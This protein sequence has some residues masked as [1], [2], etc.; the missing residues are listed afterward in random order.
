[1]KKN[2]NGLKEKLPLSLGGRGSFDFLLIS[3]RGSPVEPGCEGDH[4]T[5]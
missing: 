2:E 5:P 3:P 4:Q 1:V